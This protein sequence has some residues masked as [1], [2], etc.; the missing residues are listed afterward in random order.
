MSRHIVHCIILYDWLQKQIITK[1]TKTFQLR[2]MNASTFKFHGFH[3]KI[4]SAFYR[5]WK[6][7][8]LLPFPPQLSLLIRRVRTRSKS[9]WWWRAEGMSVFEKRCANWLGTCETTACV[10]QPCCLWFFAFVLLVG[11]L[12]TY[13]NQFEVIKASQ[14]CP[15]QF[16]RQG[17]TARVNSLR[18]LLRVMRQDLFTPLIACG[19]CV[20]DQTSWETGAC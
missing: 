12:F 8:N 5:D 3:G 16:K 15:L 13:C 18:L 11:M 1:R 6:T 19:L 20:F 10:M 4:L 2:V 7:A 9:C 17:E 14:D